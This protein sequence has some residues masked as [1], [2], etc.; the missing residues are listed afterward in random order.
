MLDQYY[1]PDHIAQN[2][3]VQLSGIAVTTFVDTSCGNGSLLRAAQSV[4][5][6]SLCIGIDFDRNTVRALQRR[7]PGWVLSRGNVLKPSSFR[8]CRAATVGR[9]CDVLLLNP[10]F[11]ENGQRSHQHKIESLGLIRC[12]IA[13]K[14]VLSSLDLIQPR[15]AIAAIIPESMWF[16]RLDE[17]ARDHLSD[18][19]EI[20]EQREI[21]NSAF[22]GARPRSIL[23]AAKIDHNK[24]GSHR[25]RPPLQ[26]V[27]SQSRCRLAEITRGGLPRHEAVYDPNGVPYLHTTDIQQI[28]ARPS[29]DLPRVRPISRGLVRG[30]QVFLP[31]VGTPIAPSIHPVFRRNTTQ[32]SD[33]IIALGFDSKMDAT[34]WSKKLSAHI[35]ELTSLYRGTGARYITMKRLEDWLDTIT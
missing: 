6:K 14:H 16:S 13:M 12:S 4:Y 30:W 31:R 9:G 1:T 2:M 26:L 15:R 17:A 20:L 3:L 22:T 21:S 25:T 18:R 29:S 34:W 32:I 5:K 35:G 10:P 7:H 28:V 11:S 23:L 27:S 8:K 19:L 33:C 24:S